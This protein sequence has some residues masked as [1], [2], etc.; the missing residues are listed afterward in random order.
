MKLEKILIGVL[1]LVVAW[2]VLHKQPTL[3]TEIRYI[4]K[5]E[6]KLDTLYRDTIV[7]KTKIRRF[8]DTIIIYRDSII[9]AKENND[10]VKII[11]FQ[12]SVIEQQ[13]YT[14]KWQ[15]TLIGQLDTIIDV[16]NK[17]NDKLK[18]SI[19][20]LNKDVQKR[21]KRSKIAHII[22][23]IGIATLFVLK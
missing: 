1:L 15:D 19:V 9:I 11:A 3:P 21:K 10:T 16:Q 5:L 4:T 12:D 8:K 22:G 20:D 7:F 13:D 18:D 17:V 2:L 23:S 14:I 6:Q